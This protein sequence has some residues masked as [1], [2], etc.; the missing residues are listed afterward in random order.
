MKKSFKKSF[1]CICAAAGF[2]SSLLVPCYSSG[3][4]FSAPEFVGRAENEYVVSAYSFSDLDA[5]SWYFPYVDLLMKEGIVKG[6]T[7]TEYNP[8]GTFTL[9][10]CS[11][12]IVRFLGLEDYA[13]KRQREL[14]SNGVLGAELWYSGYIQ[15][16]CDTKIMEPE[17]YSLSSGGF[18]A[19]NNAQTLE[20]PVKRYEFSDFITRSF[21]MDTSLVRSKAMY[22]EISDNGNHFITGGRYDAS[23]EV[24]KNEIADFESVPADSRENLL[25]AYYNGIFNGDAAGNFNPLDNLRRSEMAKVISVIIKPELRQRNEYRTLPPGSALTDENF[26]YDGWGER[27]VDRNTA[28]WLLNEVAKNL[29]VSGSGVSY[30]PVNAPEGYFIEV[31]FF[32]KSAGTYREKLKTELS[33]NSDVFCSGSE[34]CVMFTLRNSANAKVEGVLRADISGSSAPVFSNLFK[35]AYV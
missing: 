21:D 6:V 23:V 32:E 11:A 20:R 18:V 28:Y 17:K 8:D 10:E 14:L 22:P 1:I 29:S 30:T 15:T 13:A 26:V 27:T 5:N 16:L 25:K 34:I 19:I 2:L 12:V 3:G 35:S 24:Y 31:R 7:E 4:L 33:D 9:A